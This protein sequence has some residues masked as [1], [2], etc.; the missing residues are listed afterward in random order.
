[1]SL[2]WKQEEG[3]ER[4]ELNGM[5]A[6]VYPNGSYTLNDGGIIM[7]SAEESAADA[8]LWCQLYMEAD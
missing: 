8:K 5:V 1:M 7:T 3:Y 6:S 4:A 2:E